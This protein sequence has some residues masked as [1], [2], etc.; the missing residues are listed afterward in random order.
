MP[1]QTV[2]LRPYRSSDEE[3]ALSLWQRS[4]QEAYPQIDFS[5]RMDW[6]RGHWRDLTLDA[7][8]VVAECDAAQDHIAGFVAVSPRTGYLDQIVVAP[9]V[10]HHGVGKAL[11]TAAKQIGRDGLYLHVNKDNTR[12]LDFYAKC[13]FIVAGE[14]INRRSG[15]PVFMMTWRPGQDLP[16]P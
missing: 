10:Q 8:V 6:F 11:I 7:K 2:T 4:W 5:Q 9:E 13:G 1:Q 14:D 15:A 16:E 12:A 3:P